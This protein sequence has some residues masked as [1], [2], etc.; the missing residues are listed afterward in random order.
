MWNFFHLSI[1][2]EQSR[3]REGYFGLKNQKYFLNVSILL[4]HTRVREG[5]FGL[6]KSEI[7]FKRKY[8]S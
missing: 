4:E 6:K 3:V 7:F 8:P 1:L 2:L 5:Y